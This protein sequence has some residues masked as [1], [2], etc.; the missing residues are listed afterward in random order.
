MFGQFLLPKRQATD[1][2]SFLF[3]NKRLLLVMM[4]GYLLIILLALAFSK[5]RIIGNIFR[6]LKQVLSSVFYGVGQYAVRKLALLLLFF[7][8]FMF[9]NKTLL[10]SS[11]KTEKCTTNTDEILDSAS[12]LIATPK[13]LVV[14]FEEDG[15]LRRALEQSFLGRLAK[16]HRFVHNAPISKEQQIALM[17]QPLDS[18]FFFS[19]EIYLCFTLSFFAAFANQ[20]GLIAFVSTRIYSESFLRVFYLRRS[21]EEE[22]KRFVHSR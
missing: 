19:S 22:K 5:T 11:I 3:E 7:S 18:M 16:K 14:N 9:I 15:T 8:L 6:V 10:L 20:G 1:F 17:K 13:M 21:L 2:T 4:S 12:K